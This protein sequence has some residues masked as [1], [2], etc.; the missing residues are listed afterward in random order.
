MHR[1]SRNIPQ[2]LIDIV[3]PALNEAQCIGRTIESVFES[4]QSLPY[5]FELIIVDDGSTDAT[6]DIVEQY[7]NRYPIRLL[8]LT[9]N[10]G[11]ETALLAGLDHARGGATIIMDADLQH[12]TELIGKFL[13]HRSQGY[14]CVYAVRQDRD[15]E[16]ILKRLMTRIFYYGVNRG[17]SVRIPRN[18]LDFRLL[19]RSAVEALC[20]MRERV[21]FTKG[22]Y[23]WLGFRSLG[24]PIVPAPRHAGAS[25][26]NFKGL[27]QLGW[28]GLTS[29][30]D[31]PL[32]LA[33]LIGLCVA[34]FSIMYG[35]FIAAR[36]LLFGVDV[37]GWATITVAICFVGGLQLLF[38][39]VLGQYLRSVFIESKQRPN[40]LVRRRSQSEHCIRRRVSDDQLGIANAADLITR[41][42]ERS[43]SSAATDAA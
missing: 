33:G 17:A 42:P 7:E 16:S 37:P 15:D 12:P 27:M 18:A 29:F 3:I 32:R 35:I 13:E 26:F 20:S 8:Q 11:K 1:R 40:Y 31:W 2:E 38:L 10:F 34:S 41:V 25:R 30:S 39:G 4:V 36:T 19:D 24:V 9:R 22:L 5:R 28:D 14:D 21:R 6:A 43:P 23:A